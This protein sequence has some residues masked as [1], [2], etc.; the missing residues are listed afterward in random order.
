MS[1]TN[2]R[3]TLI[4]LS[5]LLALNLLAADLVFAQKRPTGRGR[6]ITFKISVPLEFKGRV[7]SGSLRKSEIAGLLDLPVRNGNSDLKEGYG[8]EMTR[9][10]Y[11]R[12][13]VTTCRQWKKARSE[14]AYAASTFDMAMESSMIHTCALLFELQRARLP[15]KSF[16]TNPRVS[17]ADLD[18]LPADILS[19]MPE[20]E[21]VEKQLSKS[22]V[23]EVVAK[24]DI[25]KTDDKMI[26]LSYGGFHQSIWEAVR[27]DFDGDGVEDILVFTGGRAEGGTMGFSDYFLL[28]RTGPTGPLKLIEVRKP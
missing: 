23:S 19:Y 2:K 10:D 21:E 4:D 12:F 26:S 22:T 13:K 3:I 5:L 27:A 11:A 24:A 6:E 8:V 15:L 25:E 20:D 28:T 14:E 9:P 16:V 7:V 17:L 18:L 1:P